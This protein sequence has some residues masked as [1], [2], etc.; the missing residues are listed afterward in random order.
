MAKYRWKFLDS[1]IIEDSLYSFGTGIPISP[2]NYHSFQLG[3]APSVLNFTINPWDENEN[4]LIEPLVTQY[5]PFSLPDI[6][7]YKAYGRGLYRE[8]YYRA[9]HPTY[10]AQNREIDCYSTDGTLNYNIKLG[11]I[12]GVQNYWIINVFEVSHAHLVVIVAATSTATTGTRFVVPIASSYFTTAVAQ[13]N[14]P[15][16]LRAPPVS[17]GQGY[18]DDGTDLFYVDGTP[19]GF[20]SQG[21]GNMEPALP[22][23]ANFI[24][25][26]NWYSNSIT[27]VPSEEFQVVRL[28]TY[29]GEFEETFELLYDVDSD[30]AGINILDTTSTFG[31]HRFPR[32]ALKLARPIGI[33]IPVSLA[34]ESIWKLAD[35]ENVDLNYPVLTS[36]QGEVARY[37]TGIGYRFKNTVADW[38]Y[39]SCDYYKHV[40]EMDW[41]A[42]TF[43]KIWYVD[44]EHIYAI[45]PEQDSEVE[46]E[47]SLWKMVP[48]LGSAEAGPHKVGATKTRNKYG[49]G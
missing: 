13:T 19:S 6:V 33:D 9:Y 17:Y 43:Y 39:R 49:A 37:I 2:L 45:T 12:N 29:D 10:S 7:N 20:Y 34:G 31:E 24:T 22:S 1:T 48:A 5:L 23:G 28:A 8:F 40:K 32:G 47:W 18:F 15:S 27:H 35:D 42:N 41:W 36:Q 4:A 11:P 44:D 25:Q 16:L 30:Y 26:W 21:A 46:N 38:A 3:I 14:K